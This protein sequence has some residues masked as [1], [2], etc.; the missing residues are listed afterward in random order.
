MSFSYYAKAI[1]LNQSAV[2]PFYRMHASRMK[3]LC[4]CGKQNEEALKV[5][6]A[7]CSITIFIYLFS[8]SEVIYHVYTCMHPI[9]PT[10]HALICYYTSLSGRSQRQRDSKK[11]NFIPYIKNIKSLH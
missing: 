2:D 6:I 11:Y 10:L 9:V 7:C 4:T 1:A 5:L 3:L 8:L